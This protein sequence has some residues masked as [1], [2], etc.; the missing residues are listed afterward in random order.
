M[1][2]LPHARLVV[3]ETEDWDGPRGLEPWDRSQQV[4]R[5]NTEDIRERT[6]ESTELRGGLLVSMLHGDEQ[7]ETDDDGYG[8]NDQ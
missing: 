6:A 4:K 2:Q 1:L 7:G 3:S 5:F 8:E